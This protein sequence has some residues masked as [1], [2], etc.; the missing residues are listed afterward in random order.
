M[1]KTDAEIK[2]EA[3]EAQ[4]LYDKQNFMGALPL[5]E[6]LHQQQPGSVVFDE[7]LAMT[8]LAKLGQQS[9]ADQ[10][11]TR[12]RAKDLLLQAKAA[13]DD[14]NLLQ[15]LL[16]KMSLA[17][18]FGPAAPPVT[19][20]EWFEKA[21]ASF[22]SGD[23]L[24]AVVFYQKALEVN[25]QYY[26]AATFAGDAEYK[27]GHTAEAGKFFA[28]AIAI[29][30]D[31]E[32]AHRYWGDCLEKAG[33]HKRAEEEFI[34]AIVADPYTRAPRVGLKQWADAN[35]AR[36]VPPPIKLP[37]RA[38]PGKNGNVNITLSPS[39]EKTDQET[40]L[41]L[42]YSMESALWQG[43]EFKK[44]FPDEKVYRH[45]L[46]EEVTSIR[47]MFSVLKEQKI[48]EGK[49]SVSTRTLL[50][51]DKK[52]MLECWI[53]LDNPDQ[54]I[55]QDYIAYRKDHRDLLARYIAQYDVHQN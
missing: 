5:Y 38:T 23:L 47:L 31:V 48:P 22:S 1:T 44:H 34:L 29:N 25:P 41:A 45:S 8:L 46:L 14:S 32:T 36:I 52:G 33:E 51:L 4:A 28:Q 2:K 6:D 9:G 27:L 13:G 40:S 50:D 21:E 35:H 15:I 43:D 16:E 24:G 55:A 10:E 26:S 49:L 19:G 7:C 30:P 54:G 3:A 42:T 12:K 53:L 37:A 17:D 11:A 20:H 39:A 18:Q